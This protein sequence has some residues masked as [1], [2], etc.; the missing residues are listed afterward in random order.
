MAA[1]ENT[2]KVLEYCKEHVGEMITQ[3]TIAEAL[4]LT[5]KQVNPMVTYWAT[6]RGGNVL[7]RSEPVE[8]TVMEMV[9]ANGL[10]NLFTPTCGAIMGGLALAKVEY[11][12]WLKWVWKLILIIALANI[13]I[14]TAAMLIL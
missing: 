9:A 7:Q 3:E 10:V 8:T 1:S 14:L 6:A 4:G 13:V 2:V 11:T 12:T 5:P